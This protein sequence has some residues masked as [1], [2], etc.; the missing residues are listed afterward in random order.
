MTMTEV[1]AHGHDHYYDGPPPFVW[2]GVIFHFLLI[3][4]VV[5]LIVKLR[6][7]RAIHGGGGHYG[8]RGGPHWGSGHPSMGWQPN[9]ST[10]A[11]ILA[12]RYAKGEID[13]AQY[14][15]KAKQ[16]GIPIEPDSKN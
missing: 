2:V 4:L 13:T 14:Q 15:E 8:W 12:E 9:V 6:S 11:Q 5:V 16:L 10:P 3:A 7:R 1:L